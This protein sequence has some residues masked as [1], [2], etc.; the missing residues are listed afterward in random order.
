MLKGRNVP[1]VNNVTFALDVGT[2]VPA[3]VRVVAVPDALIEVEPELRGDSYFVV[4][5]EIVIVDRGREIVAVLPIGSSS[6]RVE[7]RGRASGAMSLDRVQIREVQIELQRQGFEIGTPD[8]M[9][10]PRTKQALIAF[11]KQRGFQATG[12]IDHDTFGALS[13]GQSETTGQAP[14]GRNG[15]P[16]DA[17]GNNPQSNSRNGNAS[18]SRSESPRSVR[19]NAGEP[20]TTGQSSGNLNGREGNPSSP[21]GE[22]R[23][24]ENPR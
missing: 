19:P 8:G 18:Q 13:G 16:S 23:R 17:L 7:D 2:A 21:Q 15:L 24:N 10:G 22:R 12:E 1:R 6:A 3:T 14:A 11:Q 5:D 9:L 20:S 4:R